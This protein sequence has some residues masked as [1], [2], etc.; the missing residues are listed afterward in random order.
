MHEQ[1]F[2]KVEVGKLD[3]L[4]NLVGELV[5][6]GAAA[7]LS[8]RQGS[9]AAMA[10]AN[11]AVATLVEHIRDASLSLRMVAIGEVF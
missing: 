6:A 4:I 5:I 2:I 1:V 7:S 3:E 10:E 8:L 9:P 11:E